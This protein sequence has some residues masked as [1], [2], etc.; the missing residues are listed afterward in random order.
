MNAE[1]REKSNTSVKRRQDCEGGGGRGRRVWSL[2]PPGSAPFLASHTLLCPSA[3]E[4]VTVRGPS[5]RVQGWPGSSHRLL[6][7]SGQPP[8]ALAVREGFLELQE[9]P[10]Q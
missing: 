6:L 3:V 2:C 7:P 9:Q 5:L 8:A 1:G 10:Q 4:R